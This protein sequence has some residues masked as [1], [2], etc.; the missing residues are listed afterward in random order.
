MLI[1][2]VL[3]AAVAGLVAA[4]TYAVIEVQKRESRFADIE[5]RQYKLTVAG[6]VADAKRE[7]IEAG[8]A[9][10]DAILRAANL[11]KE[12]EQLKLDVAKAQLELEKYRAPRFIDDNHFYYLIE[13]VKPFS[14][15][16]FV[17][18]PY[19]SNTES[20]AIADRI[21]D[22]LGRAGWTFP[23]PMQKTFIAGGTVGI[24]IDIDVNASQRTRAAGDALVTAL[25]AAGLAALGNDNNDP[26]NVDRISIRV[27]S[28]N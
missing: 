27:G 8:K 16:F 11:E 15:Q 2:L 18:A 10:G 12:S 1:G 13:R 17:I 6:Q 5:L 21:F 23:K 4:V 22:A 26:A 9:A 20:I 3:V 7:G 14:G 19:W 25:K 28:K 24:F